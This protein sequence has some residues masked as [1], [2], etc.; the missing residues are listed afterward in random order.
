MVVRAQRGPLMGWAEPEVDESH[1]NMT[2]ALLKAFITALSRE[3]EGRTAVS[4]TVDAR[5][6]ETTR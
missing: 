1:E 5:E 2:L 3:L 6:S 4:P